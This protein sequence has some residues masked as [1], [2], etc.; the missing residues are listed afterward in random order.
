MDLDITLRTGAWTVLYARCVLSCVEVSIIHQEAGV[1]WGKHYLVRRAFSKS[2]KKEAVTTIIRIKRTKCVYF[3]EK[4]S[5]SRTTL[6]IP[7]ATGWL[8]SAPDLA[9]RRPLPGC[10]DIEAETQIAADTNQY[11]QYQP[12]NST[13]TSRDKPRYCSDSSSK[14]TTRHI[15]A[16][17]TR[18][19]NQPSRRLKFYNH[20]EGWCPFSIVS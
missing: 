6:C 4:C 7:E 18:A 17:S 13:D 20:G 3:P 16:M 11:Q 10:R 12:G 5:I 15:S 19:S 1:R 9:W 2:C 8:L 14:I